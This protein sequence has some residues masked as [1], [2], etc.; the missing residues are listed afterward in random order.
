MKRLMRTLALTMAVAVLASGCFGSF[1][2]LRGL[3]GFNQG[4]GEKWAQELV[5]LA[6]VIIPVYE[7]LALGD[8]IIF[9][10][11][12]F[13]A[14]SGPIGSKVAQLEDGTSVEVTGV[15]KDLVRVRRFEG[16]K[17]IDEAEIVRVG[18]SAMML[19]RADGTVLNTVEKLPDG[20]MAV[21]RDGAL[22]VYGAG[23][24]EQLK[25]SA[26]NGTLT[27]DVRQMVFSDAML[28]AQ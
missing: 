16:E 15:D 26:A 9:N 14:T 11:I 19:R 1:K 2:L 4:V 23:Q 6:F 17:V 8:I 27:G 5:F 18:E 12:E 13:W 20:S 24:V 10:T 28:A 3:W 22:R 7:V 25:A 21:G